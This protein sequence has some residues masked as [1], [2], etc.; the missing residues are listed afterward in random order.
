MDYPDLVSP[1]WNRLTYGY[2]FNA[3]HADSVTHAHDMTRTTNFL[4]GRF[5]KIITH[6]RYLYKHSLSPNLFPLNHE[7]T[8]H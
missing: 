1:Y 6:T 4:V 2:C 5:S 7:E 3:T 8:I